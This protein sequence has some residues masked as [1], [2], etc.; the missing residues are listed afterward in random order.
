[1][2]RIYLATKFCLVCHKVSEGS[3][4][5]LRFV[6]PLYLIFTLLS[7]VDV[8]A[9]RPFVCS[10][11]LCTYQ[12]ISL[13]MG[14]SIEDEIL[15]NANVVDLLVSLAYSAG[16]DESTMRPYPHGVGI[17]SFKSYMNA[18]GGVSA[19][20]RTQVTGVDTRWVSGSGEVVDFKSEPIVDDTIEVRVLAN[21][22]VPS[23]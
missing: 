19:W 1:M 5:C 3:F 22:F 4:F 8:E 12:Y 9:L 18:T 17:F 15:H 13:G 2:R 21:A 6:L 14:P 16:V 20:N 7:P 10:N 11:A 23:H